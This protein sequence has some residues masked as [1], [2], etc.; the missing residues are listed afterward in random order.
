MQTSKEKFSKWLEKET[1]NF[2]RSRPKG[3][4]HYKVSK[5]KVKWYRLGNTN[6]GLACGLFMKYSKKKKKFEK[7]V[8]LLWDDSLHTVDW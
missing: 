6:D 8:R 4:T 1:I 2:R 5:N 3:A 7:I